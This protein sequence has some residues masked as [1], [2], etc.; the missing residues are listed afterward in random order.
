M[1]IINGTSFPGRNSWNNEESVIGTSL[2]HSSD[3]GQTKYN[4]PDKLEK[5]YGNTGFR[6]KQRNYLHMQWIGSCGRP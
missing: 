4:I 1:K 2:I 3:W 6:N 5:V